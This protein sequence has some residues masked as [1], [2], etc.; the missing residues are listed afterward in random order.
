MKKEKKNLKNN[1]ISLFIYDLFVP[2]EY[3]SLNGLTNH[4][5]V[6]NSCND[7]KNVLFF[8]QKKISEI[9]RT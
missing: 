4:F 3:V 8:H 6:W 1:Y 7:L 5:V 9:I 2:T